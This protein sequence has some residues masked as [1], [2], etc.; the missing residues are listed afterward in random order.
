MSFVGQAV[1]AGEARRGEPRGEDRASKPADESVQARLH[2]YDTPVRQLGEQHVRT[3]P[4]A[5]RVDALAET[6]S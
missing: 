6:S 4:R 1:H 5:A 2:E 3:V